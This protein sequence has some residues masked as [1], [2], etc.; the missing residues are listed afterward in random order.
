MPEPLRTQRH[1]PRTLLLLGLT[2]LVAQ[3]PMASLAT[4]PLKLPS[5]NI[6]QGDQFG[7]AVS[8]SGDAAMVSAF[9]DSSSATGVITT[10]T[11]SSTGEWNETGQLVSSDQL[12]N[13]YFGYSVCIDGDTALVGAYSDDENG[14]NSGCA[15]IFEQQETGNW[16]ETAK[17]TALDGSIGDFFGYSV[18]ISGST[19]LVGALGDE[20]SGLFSGSAYIFEQQED[21]TWLEAAKLTA[22]DGS[23]WD[24]FG[25]SVA[26]SGTTALVGAP[27]VDG[28]DLSSG[29]AYIFSKQD[30]G[31]W[32]QAA[33]LTASDGEQSD[34]FGGSVSLSGETA[35][36][37]ASY[38]DQLDV[39]EAGSAYVFQMDNNGNWPQVDKLAASNAQRDDR[40]GSSVSL[41]GDYASVAAPSMLD[42]HCPPGSVYIFQRT[43]GN[44]WLETTII[45]PVDGEVRDGFGSSVCLAGDDLIIGMP[46]DDDFGSNSGSAYVTSLSTN[47]IDQDCNSNGICDYLDIQS[48]LSQDCNANDVPDDCD[49]ADGTSKDADGNGIPDECPLLLCSTLEQDL[50]YDGNLG[51]GGYAT[52]LDLAISG[53]IAAVLDTN[54]DPPHN[55]FNVHFF[56]REQGQWI[57]EA[58]RLFDD[59][60]SS[61]YYPRK[62]LDISGDTVIVG[63][64][65]G[66]GGRSTIYRRQGGQWNVESTFD[67]QG[68]WLY[69]LSVSISGEVA[70]V[71]SDVDMP[72]VRVYRR[73]GSTW[74]HETTLV[75]TQGEPTSYFGTD[76]AIDGNTIIVGSLSAGAWVFE[77]D[78]EDWIETQQL[79]TEGLVLGDSVDLEGDVAVVG[80]A[81][82]LDVNHAL[83]YRRTGGLWAPEQALESQEPK[84]RGLGYAVRISG[85]LIAVSS[86]I[87]YNMPD[88]PY[89]E[90]GRV[91]L[92][93]FED[94]QWNEIE[95]FKRP[96]LPVDWMPSPR[97]DLSGN[98]IAIGFMHNYLF[99]EVSVFTVPP[100]NSSDENDCNLN[101]ICDELDIASGFSVDCDGNGAP[102]SC[103][104]A[105]GLYNDVDSNGI[106][107]TCE[108]D[109]D[110]DLIPDHYEIEQGLE[111]DCN[112]NGVPDSCDLASGHSPDTNGD[113]VPD[114]CGPDFVITVATN[115][116]AMFEDIQSALDLSVSGSTIL[117][118]PGVYLGPVVLPTHPVVL[119]SEVGSEATFI[120]GNTGVT[121]LSVANQQS[122]DTVVDG[123]SMVGGDV[124]WHGGGLLI[125]NA[126][127]TIRNCDIVA[128]RAA[129]GGGLYVVAGAPLLENCHFRG[130]ESVN[131]GG[132]GIAINGVSAN[133]DPVEFMNCLIST[134]TATQAHP[135][136]LGGGGGLAAFNAIVDLRNTRF[137]YNHAGLGGAFHM[138]KP[139]QEEFIAVTMTQCEFEDNTG[140]AS[141][142]QIWGVSEPSK[143]SLQ[144]ST[145][146]G[147][148]FNDI[149]GNWQDLGGNVAYDSCDCPDTNGDGS[150]DV[151]DILAV[152]DAWG[153]CPPDDDCPEDVDDD[154]TVGVNDVL[155]V[156]SEW[157]NC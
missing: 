97:V 65:T 140:L 155:L 156:I 124:T 32:L 89:V 126:A 73:Y 83:V 59:D 121:A 134:N 142:G 19:A 149:F 72:G 130:N 67:E 153:D 7:S 35:L 113:G 128:N 22:A 116:S 15:Y 75:Q 56:H 36:I 39:G 16:L 64:T 122:R 127:P 107:D 46:G 57:H 146:C 26:I 4:C 95:I 61:L 115:G 63:S 151:N 132:G 1:L 43:S 9:S 152:I 117:V 58:T 40:F 139:G 71:G 6:T 84:T 150:V 136:L 49:I 118:S 66:Y 143:V 112:S 154:G 74:L 60:E 108:T 41:D 37:G 27:W 109:C 80:R 85:D 123:F 82:N 31:N 23:G 98:Q 21:G 93:R 148:D 50:G 52:G 29:G 25:Q 45:T 138:G 86:G 5:S 90:Q 12:G 103:D 48:G 145:L 100:A 102:D 33:K 51:D 81:H 106:P 92:F 28:N 135:P 147:H 14:T 79:P 91:H 76:V 133:G 141:V 101:W 47:S 77:Y 11:R 13:D 88:D 8:I 30:D 87:N 144:D 55:T 120:L 110:S 53:D 17:L 99:T 70:V 104:I 18:A 3:T 114:E 111:L 94:D 129:R 157:G 69:G 24:K 96:E 68:E 42:G 78:G 34:F 2:S 38:S 131:G 54:V 105:D 44:D 20:D 62:S 137:E 125:A 10:Y 119:V